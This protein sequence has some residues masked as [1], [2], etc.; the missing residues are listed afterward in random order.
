MKTIAIIGGMGPQAGIHAHKRVI[1]RLIENGQKANIVHISLNIEHFF[2][3][4]KVIKLS[5]QH[6]KILGSIQADFGFIACNTAHHFFKDFQNS[7][8]FEIIN[9]LEIVKLP[10]SGK[11][12]CSPTAKTLKLF[13]EKTKFASLKQITDIG[14]IIHRINSG[15]IIQK[16][17]LKSI[18]GKTKI[19][20]FACTEISMLAFNDNLKGIDTLEQTIDEVIRRIK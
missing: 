20:I 7:V 6:K 3:N 2:D 14:R 16:G 17:E 15:E 11:V 8:Q 13:G 5:Q 19:P 10:D 1:D 4:D 12:F 9:I 18:I